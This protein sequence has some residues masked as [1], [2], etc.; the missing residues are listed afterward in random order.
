ME[1]FNFF[2]GIQLGERI[3]KHTDNL[4]RTLQN[5]A[6]SAAEGQIVAQ[7]SVRTLQSMHDDDSLDLFWA[8]V[9]SKSQHLQIAPPQLPRHRKVPAKL[10]IGSSASEQV[11]CVKDLFRRQYFEAA[12]LV[13]NCIRVCFDQLGY[14]IYKNVESLLMNAANGESFDEEFQKVADFYKNDFN[15]GLLRTQLESLSASFKENKDIS[16]V[17]MKAILKYFRST[18]LVY[19]TFYSE[20]IKLLKLI[21]VM[22]ATNAISERSLSALKS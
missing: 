17:D 2:F 5:G 4:S 13:V 18:L 20:V 7:L 9:L 14:Q 19:R 3:L 8:A 12:D 10:E 22:P 16:R 1:K 11:D 21:L 15:S 6:Y